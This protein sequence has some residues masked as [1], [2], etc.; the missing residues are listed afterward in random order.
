MVVSPFLFVMVVLHE[1]QKVNRLKNNAVIRF[2]F[3]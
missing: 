2:G 1:K 3:T